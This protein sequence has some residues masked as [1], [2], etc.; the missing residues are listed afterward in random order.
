MPG[1]YDTTGFLRGIP[2]DRPDS[3]QVPTSPISEDS[4]GSIARPSSRLVAPSRRRPRRRCTNTHHH[5]ECGHTVRTNDPRC[6]RACR[7]PRW[8]PKRPRRHRCSACDDRNEEFWL[9]EL[10]E[11]TEK[12]VQELQG[13]RSD[14]YN[15]VPGATMAKLEEFEEAMEMRMMQIRHRVLP[16]LWDWYCRNGL[17]ALKARVKA[18][19]DIRERAEREAEAEMIR[20]HEVLAD[21]ARAERIQAAQAR[22][23]ERFREAQARWDR[24]SEEDLQVTLARYDTQY[25]EQY[26]GE[27][28]V[29]RRQQADF[30][31]ALTVEAVRQQ[32]SNARQAEIQR[33]E[34][35]ATMQQVFERFDAGQSAESN[36]SEAESSI[37]AGQAE[38]RLL[39][40]HDNEPNP[41]EA[42]SFIDA[43]QVL[44]SPATIPTATA[45]MLFDHN[46]ERF[47]QEHPQIWIPP[48][49]EPDP[50]QNEWAGDAAEV[51]EEMLFSYDEPVH[52]II[53]EDLCGGD[54]RVF[55][56]LPLACLAQVKEMLEDF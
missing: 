21:V 32:Q 46:L 4:D 18:T 40:E 8:G 43:T 1:I 44:T 37:P 28:T 50:A 52:R 30:R 24:D 6:S 55:E 41:L 51:A 38:V 54:I 31:I 16:T 48:R 39:T 53:I 49:R 12:K 10:M 23:A 14:N 35:E 5:L 29:R 17:A 27:E 7:C 26:R 22:I 33:S 47:R 19:K 42:E 15:M 25:R 56:S 11:E 2:A 13:L 34:P 3:P 36:P 20:D 9:L 45:V